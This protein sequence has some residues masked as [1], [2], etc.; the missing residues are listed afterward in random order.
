MVWERSSEKLQNRAQSS[1]LEVD[2][3]SSPDHVPH[4]FMLALHTNLAADVAKF[5]VW[6][7]ARTGGD[8]EARTS[9]RPCGPPTTSKGGTRNL[10]ELNTMALMHDIPLK[11][12]KFAKAENSKTD[13]APHLPRIL[14]HIL[15][16]LEL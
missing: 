16:L 4:P 12:H 14:T 11:T 15:T 2:R 13:A 5:D 10:H 6:C 3:G 8:I 9:C 7:C 1:E